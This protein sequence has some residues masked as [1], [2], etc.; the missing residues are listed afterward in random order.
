M[1]ALPWSVRTY[2]LAV[3]A[4]AVV[5]FLLTMHVAPVN[6]QSLVWFGVLVVAMVVHLEVSRR[7]E[8]IR[9][10]S[11]EGVGHSHPQDVWIFA[12]LLLLPPPLVTAVILVSYGYSWVRVYERRPPMHRKVFSAATV[13][14]SCWAAGAVLGV[15]A[16]LHTRP[17]VDALHGPVG[18]AALVAAAV[19][20]VVI[21]Y[22]LVWVVIRMTRLDDGTPGGSFVD[23]LVVEG[24]VGLGTAVALVMTVRPWLMPILL[25]TALALH[26]G[27]L[28]PQFR[29]AS[30]KDQKT[31]LVSATFWHEMA[32]RQIARARATEHTIGVLMVDLDLFKR[33]NDRYG[34]LAGD[35]VLK[36]VASAMRREVRRY[37]IIG[38]FGGEEFAILVPDAEVATIRGTAERVRGAIAELSVPVDCID[39]TSTVINDLTASV[40]ASVYPDT[41]TDLTGL[42][43]AADAALYLAK[44]SGRDQTRLAGEVAGAAS[45]P[46][47]AVEITAEDLAKLQQRQ[48]SE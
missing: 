26:V 13:M 42:M 7:L 19:L 3:D 44:H 8:R 30:R 23:Q 47:P 20:Y 5:A 38:R 45:T 32:D 22:G 9:E 25:C 48:P 40:G 33:I 1:A 12:A 37:D 10:L 11:A 27:T 31:G 43:M 46:E 15:S 18:L 16:P 2:V 17:L 24:A 36:A 41:A 39:G 6:H 34:H 4:L 35:Q 21:N 29:A 28:L 14:L